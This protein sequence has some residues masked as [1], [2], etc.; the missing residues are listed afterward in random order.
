MPPNQCKQHRMV[1]R[2]P[3]TQDVSDALDALSELSQT[4]RAHVVRA[5]LVSHLQA[6]G[7]LQPYDTPEPSPAGVRRYRKDTNR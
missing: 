6:A 7:L 3:V 2:F 1:A 5:A 4:S